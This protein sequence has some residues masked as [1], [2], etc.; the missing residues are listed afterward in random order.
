MVVEF[1]VVIEEFKKSIVDSDGFEKFRFEIEFYVDCVKGEL[2]FF[3]DK[4][5]FM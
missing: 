2:L 1:K 3:E 5:E 4:E